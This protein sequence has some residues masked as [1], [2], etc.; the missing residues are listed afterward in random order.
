MKSM[1]GFAALEASEGGPV[2][3]WDI[4]TVNARGLDIR[5]R[6]PEGAD[7]LEKAARGRISKAVGRGN[8][9]L[10]L[11][12]GGTGNGASL[13]VNETALNAA[14]SALAQVESHAMAQGLSLA[15]CNAADVLSVRGVLEPEPASGVVIDDAILIGD[16]DRLLQA[17]NEMRAAE[18]A[19]LRGV[20]SVQIDEIEALTHAAADLVPA[21]GAHIETVFLAALQRLQNAGADAEKT[22]HDVAALAVKAD[23]TEEL[24]RLR[25]HVVSA[26]ALL[27]QDAPVGRKLDF[28][29]QEFNREANTLCSKAQF[30]ELTQIG[31][32]LKSVVDQMREQV[33]NVE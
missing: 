33:Q 10:T 27:E 21:R 16:L 25:A 24:D 17:L 5:M 2:R 20:L 14:L 8:V 12:L 23:V 32:G 26:R 13:R 9:S 22:R 19:E 7:A 3:S 11:K 29:T 28:L 15:P 6:L 1:T 4:R 31:L 30:S 18:G